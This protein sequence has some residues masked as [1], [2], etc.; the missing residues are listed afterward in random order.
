M[1]YLH[2]KN[3]SLHLG[4]ANKPIFELNQ[5]NPSESVQK[6]YFE[7]RMNMVEHSVYLVEFSKNYNNTV[8]ISYNTIDGIQSYDSC[9]KPIELCEMT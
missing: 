6:K 1:L 3:E 2:D 7:D 5:G 4:Y 8:V 9:Y